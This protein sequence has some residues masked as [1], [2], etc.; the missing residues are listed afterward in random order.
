MVKH[1]IDELAEQIY[2][3]LLERKK[4]VYVFNGGLSVSGLQHVGRLRGEII[5]P[6][7]IRRILEKKG[8]KIKQYITL[9]TQDAWKGKKG[10]LNAFP[11]PKEAE[12]Y[13]GWPLIKL[14]D[15][16]GCHKNWV[17]HFWSD[18]GPYIKE[19]TD[20]KI[21]L[22]TTT[23]LYRGK[24]KEFTKITFEKREEV[25]RVINK[26]RGRKPYPEGWIPFEP[27]CSKCGRIDSTEATEIV[28]NEHVRYEC[29]NCGNKDT[30][31]ISE[32]K[33]NWRIE[34]VGIWWSLDV[35]FEPY[36]KDHATPGGSRDSCVDL[37]VNVYGFNPP[38]GTPYEWVSMRTKDKQVL[39]MSS[40]GFLG[41]TPKDWLEVAHPHIYRFLVLKTPPMKKL[42][43]SLYEIPQYYS[44]YFK[45][46]RI[47]YGLEK[48]KNEEE[49]ILKRSYELSYPHGGPPADPPEQVPYTHIAILSQILPREKWSS[50]ALKRLKMSGHLPEKP[51]E[52]GV[53]RIMEMM[54]KAY[55]WVQ[56][57]GGDNYKV[58][59][60]PE[61]TPE[62]LNEISDENKEILRKMREELEKITEWTEENTKNAMINATRDL[63]PAKRKKLYEDFYKLFLGKPYGP[64][65][66][67]LLALLGREEALKYLSKI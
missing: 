51:T 6:E 46:E 45:A 3:K 5:L 67:P 24:L 29:K 42:V 61:P 27:I 22:I 58:E 53:K 62:I 44:Q 57:Y 1:W 37:A 49:V 15:P 14:P 60:L 8:L 13:K 10:Q 28:D 19:F 36:G 25:R 18:F 32:G 55:T 63:D 30:T 11:D 40:S 38:E 4:E 39:D 7:T 9:Y 59:L 2:Q 16:Y 41:F 56:K 66:A 64:R 21:E 33:L 12:K 35:D 34:W 50:E 54:E 26:Y 20:G 52:Y 43:V 65:A 23:E 31:E 17:D 47:Y 48:A